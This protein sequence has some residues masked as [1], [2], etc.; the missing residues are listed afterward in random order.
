MYVGCY[1][2]RQYLTEHLSPGYL[3]E[4][5][6]APGDH[7]I[8]HLNTRVCLGSVKGWESANLVTKNNMSFIYEIYFPI[9]VSMIISDHR[10]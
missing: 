9:D 3:P 4:S 2:L 1:L 10:I 6:S 8:A 7:L 5:P